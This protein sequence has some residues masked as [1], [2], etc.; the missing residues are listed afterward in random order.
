MSYPD[1]S[2][3]NQEDPVARRGCRSNPNRGSFQSQSGS[4]YAKAAGPWST[5]ERGLF[6]DGPVIGSALKRQTPRWSRRTP[7]GMNWPWVTA[8]LGGNARSP[9]LKPR[10]TPHPSRQ[11]TQIPDSS[12]RHCRITIGSQG[13]LENTRFFPSGQNPP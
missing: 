1:C 9:R 7:S 10:T 13:S 6:G 3:W 2:G 8:P 11:P 5:A 4:A 12:V